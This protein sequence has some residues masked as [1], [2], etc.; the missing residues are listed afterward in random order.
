MADA[1]NNPMVVQANYLIEHRIGMTKDENRFFLSLVSLIS[2]KDDNTL[3]YQ[4]PVS[5]F[6]E[7]WGIDPDRKY[8]AIKRVCTSLR[9]RGF[10]LEAIDADGKRMYL[11]T[12]ILAGSQYKQGEAVVNVSIS[13][14][15]K[16]F[17]QNLHNN[18][19]PYRLRQVVELDRAGATVSTIR[20]YEI[21]CEWLHRGGHIYT[22]AE[23]REVLDLYSY[24][25][26]KAN[27]KKI[28]AVD[29]NGQRV[30]DKIKYP[31]VNGMKEKIINPAVALINEH[32]DLDVS[33]E[34]LGRGLSAAVKF[35]VAKK[36]DAAPTSPSPTT[37]VLAV[38][39]ADEEP[40]VEVDAPKE[41]SPMDELLEGCAE[42]LEE[43]AKA[44][45]EFSMPEIRVL[46]HY[47]RRN[48]ANIELDIW[49]YFTEQ[50][51]YVLSKWGT[52]KFKRKY[53]TECFR[54]N[55]A[56]WETQW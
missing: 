10:T 6:A 15:I 54:N 7:T 34:I 46:I 55:Y 12:A 19:T 14:E 1:K 31:R 27:G 47:A 48:G 17:L 43:F 45:V 40:S 20:L 23:L 41:Q 16:P 5:D 42:F 13:A 49:D 33:Y 35:T 21:C 3:T 18:F 38:S 24:K 36:A 44:G 39:A 30:R 53:I 26:I 50:R 32:T 37:E 11:D 22:I 9:H 4:I 2:G 52:I 28:Y 8:H 25:F 51:D 29:E 56:G